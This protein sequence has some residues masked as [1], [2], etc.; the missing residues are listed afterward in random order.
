MRVALVS[1]VKSKKATPAPAGELYTSA[2]FQSLRTYAQRNADAWF[3]L[4]AEHGLL[5]P[6]KVIAP[7]EKTLN[8]MGKTERDAWARAVFRRSSST[9]FR[10][11]RRS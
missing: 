3:I 11:V 2:L 9:L 5:D 7:Y 6:Q 10:R 8:R 4:S 1:C